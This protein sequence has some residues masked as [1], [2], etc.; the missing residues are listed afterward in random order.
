[1]DYRYLDIVKHIED[2]FEKHGDNCKGVDWPN[3]QDVLKRYRVMLD[4][5]R[6]D[7][8]ADQ[9][10]RYSV[11]DLGC[12][13]GHMYE[14]IKSTGFHHEYFGVDISDIFV[15]ECRRKYPDVTF[16]KLDIL[17]DDLS[18]ISCKPD[19]IIMNGVFTEKCSLS[20]EEM[21]EYFEAFIVK[22]YALC[23]KGMAFNVMSKDVDWEREDLFHLPMSDLSRFLTKNLTR[24]FIIRNDYGL[25]EYTTYVYK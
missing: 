25:Y 7:E 23:N 24:R 8:K 6:F 14:Y 15:N 18:L 21:K 9:D 16:L 2:C 12:G 22:A 4:L 20:F 3:E 17:K 5:I 1:M 13:L 10:S 19:Y 11:M